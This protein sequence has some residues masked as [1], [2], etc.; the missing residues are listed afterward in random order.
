[1]DHARGTFIF[2]PDFWGGLTQEDPKKCLLFEGVSEGKGELTLV[3]LDQNGSEIAEGGSVWL[4]LMNV[5]QMYQRATASPDSLEPPYLSSI[6][7]FDES[8]INYAPDVSQR[9]E[10]PSDEQSQC[11]V[12]VHGWKATYN[13][14]INVS[15]TMFKRLW[16]QGYK[17]RFAALRWPTETSSFSYNTSEWLAWKYGKSLHNYVEHYL[18][19]QVPSYIISIA[20]HSMGNVVTGSA[21]KRGMT[22]NKYLLMQAAIPSGCYND[23]VN[24]YVRFLSADEVRPTPD[25]AAEMGYRLHLQSVMGNVGNLVSF[26]NIDDYALATGTASIIPGWPFQTNWEKNQ[27]E[28]KPDRF[29]ALDWRAGD[30]LYSRNRPA[31]EQVS[32]NWGPAISGTYDTTRQVIDIHEA[33]S[34][35][36]R[37]R[38]KAAGAEPHNATVFHS[39]LNLEAACNFGAGVDDHS[40]QFTRPIQELMPFYR[41][42]AEELKQ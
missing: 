28:Y 27:V 37:P 11:L 5:K 3:F 36:A 31:G 9:F 1:M 26:F 14:A 2:K 30:Y 23:S 25:T 41:R 33:L 29:N 20:A 24:N 15:E 22:V 39:V 13:D 18:K 8:S 17:G 19:H 32:V 7:V 40:G 38:S 10:E 16:W 42:M 35:V 34:F 21:L 12:F 6:S 4:N